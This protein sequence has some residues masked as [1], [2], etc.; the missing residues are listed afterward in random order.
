MFK[1]NSLFSLGRAKKPVVNFRFEEK[2]ILDSVMGS[3]SGYDSRIRP[4]GINGTGTK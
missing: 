2:K 3:S 1:P 4:N